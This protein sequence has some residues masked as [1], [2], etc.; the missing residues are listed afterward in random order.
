MIRLS[1]VGMQIVLHLG[2]SRYH[3]NL[4]QDA[5]RSQLPQ[6]MRSQGHRVFAHD[7]TFVSQG[8]VLGVRPNGTIRASLAE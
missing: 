3:A 5:G 7:V 2:K 6:W 4:P 8:T 1:Y